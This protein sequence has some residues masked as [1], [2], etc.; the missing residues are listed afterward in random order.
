MMMKLGKESLFAPSIVIRAPEGLHFFE[1]L[2]GNA[3]AAAG[4]EQKMPKG[5]AALS[6]S[7]TSLL[8]VHGGDQRRSP[9]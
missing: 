3:K 1:I 8:F 4:F 5:N 9:P 2:T 7:S 6:L